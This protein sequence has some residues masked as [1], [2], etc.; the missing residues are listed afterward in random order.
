[1]TAKTR[2]GEKK[3][4]EDAPEKKKNEST[5]K[6]KDVLKRREAAVKRR[7][8]SAKKKKDVE[9]KKKSEM[10]K[11]KKNETAKKKRKR[12]S[13]VDGGSS[14]NPTKR[15]RNTASPLEHQGDHSPTPSAELPSQTDRECTPNPSLLSQPQKSPTEA[16]SEAANPLQ[17]PVTSLSL[18]GSS[19]KSP[20]HRVDEEEEI[21]SNNRDSHAPEAVIDNDAQRQVGEENVAVQPMRPVGFFFK[22]SEYGTVCKLS[23]RCHQHDFLKIIEHFE[24]SEKSWFDNHP[25]FKHL[26]HM[27]C[28]KHRKVQGL[29]M[30]LLRCM[31]TGKDRQAWFG[32]NGVPIRYS[33]REHALLSGLHCGT[34]PENYPYIER[35]KFA[36][37]GRMKF[38][39][40]HFKHLQ[41]KTREKK[42]KKQGL[43]VT[44]ADVL[45]KLGKMKADGSDERLKMA[46]LYF[47][48]RIIRGRSKNGYFIEPFI[49][50]AVDDLE[51]CINFPWGRYTFDDCMK[52]IF[53]LRDHFAVKAVEDNMQWTFPGFII[54]L[55][56]LAF[57]CI[58]VLRE[59]FR[60]PVPNYLADCP[61]MCKWKFKKTGTT[62][63]PLEDIYQ[64]LG[65][66]KVISSILNPQGREIDLL[67]EIM[68]EGT[69]EDVQLIDDLDKP[70]IAVD[71][72][73]RIL[74]EPEGK[75][76]WEDLFEMD[77]RTREQESE[78]QVSCEG[79]E[80]ARDNEEPGESCASLRELESKL[81]KKMEEGFALR[82]ETIRVLE[83]RVKELEEE[84]NQRENWS[85]QYDQFQTCG[86]SGGDAG[87][88][89]SDAGKD[90]SDAVVDT[91]LP[92]ETAPD[93]DKDTAY[94]DTPFPNEGE[95]GAEKE[96]KTEAEKEDETEA[97]KEGETEA[98]KEGEEAEKEGV[99]EAEKE[100]EEA[101]KEG[102]E[103]EKE[104]EEAEKEGETEVDKMMEVNLLFYLV[105]DDAEELPSTLEVMAEAAEKFEKEAHEEE[106]RPKRTHK[107]SRPLRSPYQPN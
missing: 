86:T 30:L 64:A 2:F 17:P 56:I 105:D 45:E 55:E 53:H 102:E 37:K 48:T 21:G 3:N 39:T 12:D 34:Y 107:P 103:A 106:T 60:D 18:S 52:E 26:F 77:V 16:P 95:T 25:P 8:D 96:D 35:M 100:G 98:E 97:E 22:P 83:A 11:K 47:L 44:E 41:K 79:H 82:D 13:G 76:F 33:I 93:A 5:A 89:P 66:T 87:K 50:Q 81:T 72:W 10:A 6:K 42:G 74:I 23:S 19:T 84:R 4:K 68:D 46:V 85:F 75:I 1:M 29:W 92:T 15:I 70:D 69:I 51:F 63:F 49:L 104:G 43:K 62:G 101:E 24:E 36:S 31:H 67:Y 9:K 99:T 54:P 40:K 61:R 65:N 28:C 73:N 78:P 91:P 38:A 27:D 88:D 90:P 59:R 20:S 14:S 94:V 58:P 71:G 80:Q 57:E 7:R 32:V